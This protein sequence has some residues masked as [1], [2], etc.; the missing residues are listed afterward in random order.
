M[1]GKAASAANATV[2]AVIL[3]KCDRTYHRPETNKKCANGA[4]Q[5]TCEPGRTEA[6]AHKWTVRYSVSSRQREQSFTG[7]ADA[8][9]FQLELSSSKKTQGQMF[10]DPRAGH[11]P[12]LPLCGKYVDG[13]EKASPATK[14][15]YKSN[16]GNPAVT[17]ALTGKSVLEVA[18]MRDEVKT[19]LN[20][21]LATYSDD[22][23][24]N[25]KRIILG[26]LDECVNAGMIPR[27]TLT[28]IELS[29]RVVTAEQFERENRGLV[30]VA[31]DVVRMLA[32]GITD[33]VTDKLGR[34]RKRV[35]PGLGVAP[36][37]Q[38]TMG[39]RIREALGVRKSDFKE[40]ADG[41]KYLHLCWQASENGKTLEPLKHRQ[42][43]QF[44]DIPVPG[45]VWNIVQAMPDGP[46][47][48]G[49]NRT[50]YM[51]YSTARNRFNRMMA[52]LGI[53]GAHTH[54]LRHQFAT[55]ALDND[56]REL[57][58]I[59]QVLGHDSVETTMRFYIHPSANAEQR[60]GKMMNARW[61]A[62]PAPKKAAGSKR[63]KPARRG[64][65]RPIAAVPAAA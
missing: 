37:L 35:I 24:G 8:R 29:A 13:L 43:G 33:T 20:K 64:T 19:L 23:R 53:E 54:S 36:W 22:Y 3:K 45:M 27:H 17:E 16:F 59:S 26:T 6:C 39:L 63:A 50:P 46:L 12:F 7:L 42:A 56:P 31:D 1:A 10:T 62:Q 65:A 57:P 38:R 47:C 52:H 34:T 25:I 14:N 60:I 40:R 11:V 48:P 41:T 58:N 21:S 5:H 28:G 4:C 32:D 51:P 49:P 18:K 2:E 15:T 55:E 30:T 9:T 44:R 61:T